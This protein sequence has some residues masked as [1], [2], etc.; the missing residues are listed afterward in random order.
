MPKS[1]LIKVIVGVILV[2]AVLAGAIT[3]VGFFLRQSQGL[4][5]EATGDSKLPERPPSTMRVHLTDPIGVANLKTG[6]ILPIHGQVLSNYPVD[7]LELWVNGK[8]VEVRKPPVG[9]DRT[10]FLALWNWRAA[11]AGT[12][13][14]TL[15]GIDR[16][17]R[18][19]YSNLVTVRV[20]DMLEQD[21][22]LQIQATPDSAQLTPAPGETPG[23]PLAGPVIKP[24]GGNAPQV[25]GGVPASG[26]EEQPPSVPGQNPPPNPDP[27]DITPPPSDGDQGPVLGEP[28]KAP[29]DVKVTITMPDA[30]S[31]NLEIEDLTHQ[32][33]GYFIERSG[34][35]EPGFYPVSVLGAETAKSSHY[36][37][38][39]DKFGGAYYYKII[40]YNTPEQRSQALDLIEVYYGNDCTYNNWNG[41]VFSDIKVIPKGPVE[42][43]HC[44][45]WLDNIVWNRL[46]PAEGSSIP[47]MS[48]EELRLWTTNLNLIT[49]HTDP[50]K[51][52]SFTSGY[53]LTS[54]APDLSTTG[55]ENFQLSIRCVNQTSDTAITLGTAKG[56]IDLKRPDQLII[57]PA[58]QFDAYVYIGSQVMPGNQPSLQ[59]GIA[60]PYAVE[61]SGDPEICPPAWQ[62][63]CTDY[64]QA[65]YAILR[66]KWKPKPCFYGY[67][68]PDAKTVCVEKPNHFEIY[69]YTYSPRD[70]NVGSGFLGDLASDG[71]YY[72]FI[73]YPQEDTE[74]DEN[75]TYAEKAA[76]QALGLKQYCVRA[77]SARWFRYMESEDF[78]E[79][80]VSL[81]DLA[82]PTGL[83]T[84]TLSPT[85]TG[86]YVNT[87]HPFSAGSYPD[88]QAG[89][90]VYELY[91]GLYVDSGSN[92]VQYGFFEFD[93]SQIT[94]KQIVSAK[95]KPGNTEG[96]FLILVPEQ[97]IWED[98][99][100]SF[101][102]GKG[103]Q[104]DSLMREW[105]IDTG[106]SRGL[107]VLN[108]KSSPGYH[109]Y[110]PDALVTHSYVNQTMNVTDEVR[111]WADGS[112]PNYGFMFGIWPAVTVNNVVWWGCDVYYGPIQLIVEY[113]D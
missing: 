77:V 23:T 11:Q 61:V 1:T 84:I 92:W 93:L 36:L 79:S 49:K 38:N 112:T 28:P 91:T 29:F 16:G 34:P 26:S 33:T 53:D 46:P 47:P 30:C 69:R 107:M 85:E 18:S 94:G 68:N 64:V 99:A 67:S 48:A 3:G 43:L 56:P 102:G 4:P 73:P 32:A 17:G 110:G 37:D 75:D 87:E 40:A 52:Y 70:T 101:P 89:H 12:Y 86:V 25:P 71:Y 62:D 95:L 59:V 51:A 50:A 20:D 6:A 21:V 57:L 81:K 103:L 96:V 19:A 35:Q 31:A 97:S 60:S 13:K 9:T 63:H 82:L 8:L 22:S 27:G 100:N 74:P 41:V 45:I 113:Y 88:T 78:Q 2:C 58:E 5:G 105:E 65:H 54:F 76:K 39:S 98:I 55:F 83:K 72:T 106:C 24:A 42:N 109:P 10:F 104:T 90:P 44:F 15:R 14:L 111:M 66:W 108:R 80:C 7:S